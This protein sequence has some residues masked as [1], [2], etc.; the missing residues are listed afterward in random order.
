MWICVEGWS[1]LVDP[2]GEDILVL[3]FISVLTLIMSSVVLSTDFSFFK[4]ASS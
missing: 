3:G 4:I 2:L 1:A